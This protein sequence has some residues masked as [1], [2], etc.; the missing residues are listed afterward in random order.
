MPR[1]Q[2]MTLAAFALVGGVTA[3]G[4]KPPPD[5]A[6]DPELVAQITGINMRAPG[7]ACPGQSIRADYEAELA[8]GRAVPFSREYDDE[9]PPPLHVVFLRRW[10]Q[11]AVS[12]EDGDWNLEDDPLETVM[13]GFRLTAELKADRSISVTHVVRPD[14]SC[15]PHAFR[16]DGRAGRRGEPGGPGPDVLVRLD[17]LSSPFYERLVVASVE[18]GT[19]PP[20]Y[21]FQ[22][23]DLVPPSDWLVVESRGGHGGRG[24]DGASGAAGAA[25]AA[26]CPGGSGG[27]GGAGSNGGPG[28]PGGSGG[29]V[30]VMAPNELPYLAG[31]VD[32]YG[33]GGPGG[34]GGK[35]GPGG[36]GGKGGAATARRCEAGE[37]GAPGADGRPGPEGAEGA[38]GPRA[39][40]ITVAAADLFPRPVPPRLQELLDYSHR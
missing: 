16:F 37:D 40:V 31:L 8:D 20:F 17:I 3:C 27:A 5:Y 36:P 21:L 15:M 32:A 25:G 13:E 24:L 34:A 28:A 2:C 19:A 14:Y 6:P 38:L 22:D 23:A 35:A 12:Q 30:T 4:S 33:T 10:S 39:R 18:V 11:E 29:H 7:R 26:G 1:M 9:N